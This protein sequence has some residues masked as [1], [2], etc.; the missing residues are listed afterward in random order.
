MSF[1]SALVSLFSS[2]NESEDYKRGKW[3]AT[4]ALNDSAK[5]K[6]PYKPEGES[7]KKWWE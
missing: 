4:E 3:E 6:P 1:L 7:G 5:N 2:S